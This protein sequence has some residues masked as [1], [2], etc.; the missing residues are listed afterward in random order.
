[1]NSFRTAL[2]I[3]LVTYAKRQMRKDRTG[4]GTLNAFDANV[5]NG[6]S[7]RC[8]DERARH[9]LSVN[10]CCQCM[11]KTARGRTPCQPWTESQKQ[12]VA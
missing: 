5:G 12:N 11:H 8:F 1:M 6:E 10:L 9:E 3:V 7:Q 4:L 2:R